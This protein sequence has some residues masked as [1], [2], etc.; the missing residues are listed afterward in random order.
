[1]TASCM[2]G[3]MGKSA[4]P[5]IGPPV[6]NILRMQQKKKTSVPFA[7]EQSSTECKMGSIKS[8]V[9]NLIKGMRFLFISK[10]DPKTRKQIFNGCHIG[11][12]GNH[13]GRDRTHAKIAQSISG[14][15]YQRM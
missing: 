12:A 14:Q 3:V 11:P 6:P 2:A 15:G 10:I 9:Q 5:I 7:K 4:P 8:F 13:E 1:M